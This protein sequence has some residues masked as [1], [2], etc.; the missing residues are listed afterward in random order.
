M[1]KVELGKGRSIFNNL[2]QGIEV[3]IPAK[4][5]NSIIFFLTFWIV[6]WVFGEVFAIRTILSDEGKAE[7]L[8]MVAWLGAWTI[9]GAYAIVSWFWS[10]K[11]KEI[12]R[13]D[14]I[15]LKHITD[16][17]LFKR[18]KEYEVAHIKELRTDPSDSSFLDYEKG[19][20]NMGFTGGT[21]VFDYGHS[22][23]KFGVDLDEA[24]A[25]HIVETL[26]KRYKSL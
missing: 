7:T 13:I 6:A 12:I 9:G 24:E 10:V 26:K 19:S 25:K 18:S 4:K 20:L 15:L 22:T 21:V 11:G 3:V 2:P 23:H 14:G 8:F 16:F 1:A 5:N 17:V